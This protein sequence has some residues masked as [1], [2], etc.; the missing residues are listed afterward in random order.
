MGRTI[1]VQ[2]IF[3]LPFHLFCALRFG[4]PQANIENKKRCR[5]GFIISFSVKPAAANKMRKANLVPPTTNIIRNQRGAT[6]SAP[7]YLYFTSLAKN[8]HNFELIPKV[9][10]A[11]VS[12][13]LPSRVSLKRRINCLPNLFIS[14]LFPSR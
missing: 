11:S 12:V 4:Y 6:I 14:F 7:K 1:L 2:P 5:N 9:K 3:V 13:T 10:N 8:N